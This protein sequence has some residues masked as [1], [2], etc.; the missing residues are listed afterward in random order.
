MIG[1]VCRA[2][3]ARGL[4][5]LVALA[6]VLAVGVSAQSASNPAPSQPPAPAPKDPLDRE[7]PRGTIRGFLSAGRSGQDELA[8]EYLNVPAGRRAA[9]LAHQLFVVLDA[10]MPARLSL[11]S[12]AAEG[13]RSDPRLP[14]QEI[15][16]TIYDGNRALEIVLDRVKRPNGPAV[17][18]F[19]ER[20][21][22]G[23]PA[24][25]EE[26]TLG[27]GDSRLPRLLT[28]TRF[29]GIRLLEWL[30][31]VLGLPVLYFVTVL[32]NKTVSPLVGRLW[33]WLFKDSSLFVRNAL[34]GPAR[35]FLLAL[36]IEWLRS[37]VPLPLLVRE[38]WSTIAALV[39]IAA[40]VWLLILVDGAVEQY[41][42]RRVPRANMPG[43]V[44]LLRLGRRVVDL[45]LIVIGVLA[46]M[47]R[48]GIDPTPA[49]AGLGVGGI[50]VALAAQKTLENVIAG[51]SLIFDQAVRVGDTL[52]MDTVV[53]TVEHIG[54][55]STRIRTA[56]RTVVS[57]PNSQIANASLTTIS[58]RDKFWFH[59]IIGLR[60]ETT[61][62][63]L[64][65]VVDGIQ[66][67]LTDH[68][69][70]ESDS[71]RVRFFRLGQFSLD[72]DVSA[73]LLA[74]DWNHFMELQERLLFG[75]T[76]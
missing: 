16:A 11:I 6:V 58:A 27:W 54:L 70:V 4:V 55:R 14:D 18:L 71:T 25:Y 59:P 36:T 34:P 62:E 26:V 37:I 17:W 8:A 68:P 65:A 41:I 67:L 42:R 33:R 52:Q 24:L 75:V 49:L 19:S 64:Q 46:A 23:I 9:D 29:A 1:A 32:L 44:S 69:S 10:R 38:F 60:Y 66:R 35:L 5:G 57:V 21:L 39:T 50:A 15:V 56:D 47:R 13:S 3:P 40:V 30:C 2:R 28:G 7:T 20:T 76:E 51:A 22:S 43:A 12:D 63:Q 72:V 31:V 48:L 53:G 61:P 73:Y 45:L 74:R